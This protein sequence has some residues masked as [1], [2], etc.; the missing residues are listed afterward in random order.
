VPVVTKAKRATAK[1]CSMVIIWVKPVSGVVEL[2][3]LL[4]LCNMV[5]MF[6]LTP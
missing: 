3:R 1:K 2:Q 4:T 6:L 5:S